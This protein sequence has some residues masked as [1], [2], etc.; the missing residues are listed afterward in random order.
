MSNGWAVQYAPAQQEVIVGDLSSLG[1]RALAY[2]DNS[3]TKPLNRKLM[4]G[5][6]WGELAQCIAALVWR[7]RKVHQSH[8]RRPSSVASSPGV[9][10]RLLG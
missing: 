2:I 3:G 1:E 10:V 6:Q 8:Q 5:K 7:S 9:A 4:A